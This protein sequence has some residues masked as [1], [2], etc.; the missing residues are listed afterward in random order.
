[1]LNRVN[2]VTFFIS[3]PFLAR[4]ILLFLK[5]KKKKQRLFFTSNS[6]VFGGGGGAKILFA[7]EC[8]PAWNP[9]YVTGQE[10]KALGNLSI[11][12]YFCFQI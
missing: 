1:L 10:V 4:N 6:A 9:S 12:A 8:R 11:K 3:T 2:T 5:K 7:P